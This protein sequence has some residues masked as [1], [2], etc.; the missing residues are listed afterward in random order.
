[1]KKNGIVRIETTRTYRN[2]KIG[3]YSE[4]KK[5][6]PKKNKINYDKNSESVKATVKVMSFSFLLIKSQTGFPYRIFLITVLREEISVVD[7][8]LNVVASTNNTLMN[9]P[10][11]NI[12]Y[13]QRL[14]DST[15]H[16]INPCYPAFAT[17]S[18][19]DDD[20][21]GYD[22]VI[23]VEDDI[24]KNIIDR[25]VFAK[26][27]SASKRIKI[28]PTGGWANTLMFAYD[29]QHSNMLTK[30]TKIIIILDR[31][32]KSEV[33]GFI[34]NHIIFKITS[35]IFSAAPNYKLTDKRSI[36]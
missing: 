36:L 21:Y 9:I 29:V 4:E 31:D 27:L 13:L 30:D 8:N 28:I 24:S 6:I 3:G 5:N 17:R 25:I 33:P 15:I 14:P 26:K 35:S 19:Y 34:K 7:K 16:I 2:P 32:V 22:F 18:L 12:F 11:A 20:G 1:M 10:A 23:F